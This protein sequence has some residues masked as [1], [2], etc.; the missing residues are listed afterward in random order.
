M[1]KTPYETDYLFKKRQPLNEIIET[2]SK[3]DNNDIIIIEGINDEET[4][5]IRIGDIKERKNTIYTYK[6]NFEELYNLIKKEIK[7]G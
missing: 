1:F 7:N 2:I 6:N 4:P 3:V 5:K